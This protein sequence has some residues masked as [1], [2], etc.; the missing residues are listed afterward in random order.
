MVTEISA[1]TM[2]RPPAAIIYQARRIPKD[3]G[4]DAVGNHQAVGSVGISKAFSWLAGFFSR[5][6]S[7]QN[8]VQ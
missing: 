2:L 8:L 4:N 3:D 1:L 5:K 6:P 7:I